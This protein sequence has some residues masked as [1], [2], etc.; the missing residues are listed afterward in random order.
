MPISRI[1]HCFEIQFD[2]LSAKGSKLHKKCVKQVNSN[3]IF[4]INFAIDS[5]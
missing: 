1:Y 5:T 2:Y 3:L 4:I